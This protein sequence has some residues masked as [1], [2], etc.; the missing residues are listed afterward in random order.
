MSPHSTSRTVALDAYLQ[1][2][3]KQGYLDR[4]S[5]A[6]VG[7]KTAKGGKSKRVR[8]DDGEGNG[9]K[10]E[11]RWG[12]RAYSEV[13]EAP[14]GQFVAEFMVGPADEDGGRAKEKERETKVNKMT[15]GIGRAAG[16][17]LDEFR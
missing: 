13:G 4:L 8:A 10:Y 15:A 9:P 17:K 16:T 2:L 7:K 11:W 5:L 1:T 6:D 14:L 3:I 12:P